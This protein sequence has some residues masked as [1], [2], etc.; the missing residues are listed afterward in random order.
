MSTDCVTVEDY[1]NLSY[2]SAKIPEILAAGTEETELA[3][4]RKSLETTLKSLESGQLRPELSYRLQSD[5]R[6]FGLAIAML[7]AKKGA[8]KGN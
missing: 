1:K 3:A 7:E 5:A 6:Y 8:K 2:L 4:L